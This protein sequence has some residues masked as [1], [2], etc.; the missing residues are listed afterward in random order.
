MTLA[1][2]SRAKLAMPIAKTDARAVIGMQHTMSATSTESV[3][4][5][6]EPALGERDSDSTPSRNAIV[7]VTSAADKAISCGVGGRQAIAEIVTIGAKNPSRLLTR[8]TRRSEGTC[9]PRGR[10]DSAGIPPRRAG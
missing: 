4:V 8:I 10:N 6:P 5:A 7:A 2:I 3:T 9:V 1:R